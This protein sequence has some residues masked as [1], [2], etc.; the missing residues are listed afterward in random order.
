M[1]IYQEVEQ[2]LVELDADG[3]IIDLVLAALQGDDAVERVLDGEVLKTP[4][5]TEDSGEQVSPVY[6]QDITVSGFRGIG[7]ETTLEIPP[8]PGLTVVV[9]RN[10]SGKS[11]F[12]E[13]LEVLLTGESYRW[14][15]KTEVWKKG[16]RNLHQGDNPK[17][18]A[19]FQV[20]GKNRETVVERSWSSPKLE[21]GKSSAQHPGEVVSDLDGIGWNEPLNLYR[22]ILS[23]KELGIIEN[24]PSS[25]HDTLSKVLGIG[26]IAQAMKSL[27]TTRL[28]R[29]RLAKEVDKELRD[30]IL[31]RFEQLE[32]PRAVSVLEALITITNNRLT[33]KKA[34]KAS[35]RRVLA[36][37]VCEDRDAF[38]SEDFTDETREEVVEGVGEELMAPLSA[39]ASPADLS[40]AT[41]EDLAKKVGDAMEAD[42]VVQKV[43][44]NRR[45]L[46]SGPSSI[47]HTE[48]PQRVVPIVEEKQIEILWF[49]KLTEW[50]RDSLLSETTTSYQDLQALINIKVPNQESVIEV[51]EELNNAYTEWSIL[52]GT[53]AEN[54]EHLIKILNL[55]LEH[56]YTHENK[57][58][59]VCGVGILDS[60]WR[61]NVEEQIERLRESSQNYRKAKNDLAN[62]M[63]NA[64]SLVE[65]PQWPDKTIIAID[66]LVSIWEQW[67]SL[68]D[69]KEDIP[70][71]LLSIYSLIKDEADNVFG[72]ARKMYSEREKQWSSALSELLPWI[73]K[74]RKAMHGRTE[75]SDIKKAEKNLKTVNENIRNTRWS[76]IEKQ[77]LEIW[78][79]LRLESN[80][81][82][83]SVQLTGGR[84]NRSVSLGVEVDNIKTD[85]L[86]VVSQGEINSMAL[87]I[88]FPRVML[89]ASPF[90]FLVIDDP[91]QSMDPARVDGLARVFA[92]VAESR[93]L[94]VFTHDNRLPESLRHLDIEH[95][96]LEVRRSVKSKV[97]V[98]EKRDPVIQ[99]FYEARAI[100]KDDDIQE[101]IAR[102]VIPGFCRS[103]L[104]AACT[105]VIWRRWLGKGK[106]HQTIE[107]KLF[108]AKKLSQK[109]SLA[110]F[111][112]ASKG[113]KVF[114]RI[115]TK[116]EKR[117]AIA[118]QDTNKGTHSKYAG[119]LANLIN[120][121]QSL[122]ERL[123]RYDT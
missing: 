57:P 113:G 89:P 15:N 13:G 7:P 5:T 100:L 73:S 55:A 23:Y 111:D 120:D 17:I 39:P 123:R 87:S 62:A 92:K 9:G 74:A 3:H 119:D 112:D 11:S 63:K 108:E 85:A 102:R 27:A 12:A 37:E 83:R 24:S 30:N 20:E 51:A 116:W 66:S 41:H 76:P 75:I 32:D 33:R 43:Y 29:E 122:A 54:A 72:Q 78:K 21:A 64:K 93:Q 28:A 84:L 94:I 104:E 22:P 47:R 4:G 2:E 44:L 81:D 42:L 96:C 110:L 61:I 1:G 95:L 46:D 25:L 82:L 107:R 19:R 50:I 101:D 56:Y 14:K 121:C 90:R 52:P 10:G 40:D 69:N 18:S 105:E 45:V 86:S 35:V 16:W 67:S 31:P 8:S 77:A 34:A 99:Y 70:E 117:F 26:V 79:N 65:P 114:S 115:S 49:D 36:E 88:F 103:G 80:V 53:E 106:K 71:H 68:P 60:N 91:I 97:T 59:P 48:P 118:F 98:L 6:L 109:A 58:C 38:L